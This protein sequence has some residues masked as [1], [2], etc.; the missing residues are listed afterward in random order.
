MTTISEL[1]KLSDRLS[2]QFDAIRAEYTTIPQQRSDAA[3]KEELLLAVETRKGDLQIAD[4]IRKEAV[5]AW[6]LATTAMPVNPDTA[7]THYAEALKLAAQVQSIIT[8][9]KTKDGDKP[10]KVETDGA[11][12]D[13]TDSDKGEKSKKEKADNPEPVPAPDLKVA[14]EKDKKKDDKKV[15][16]APV[17]DPKSDKD[18]GE[19]DGDKPEDPILAAIRGVQES[20][21][22][23]HTET[24]SAIEA[25]KTGLITPDLAKIINSLTAEQLNAII[26]RRELTAL[27]TELMN[28]L[29][30]YTPEEL[31][32]MLANLKSM[33]DKAERV[34]RAFPGNRRTGNHQ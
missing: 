29:G 13:K 21:D 16:P 10:T 6:K 31:T 20:C 34:R 12:K 8:F 7:D 30:G 25:L 18:K 23:N 1:N 17:P 11:G 4:K 2:A 9:R 28:I 24:K 33:S 14:G 32:V 19:K 26:N 22:R 3:G 15:D 27:G 5:A